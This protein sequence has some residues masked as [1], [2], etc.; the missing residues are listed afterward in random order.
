MHKNIISD[1]FVDRTEIRQGQHFP[2]NVKLGG[3]GIRV[4]ENQVN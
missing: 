2:V 3:N 4:V 1:L